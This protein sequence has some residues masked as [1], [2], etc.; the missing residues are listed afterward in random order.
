MQNRWIID[1]APLQ[2]YFSAVIFAPK[3]S[4]IRNIFERQIPWICRQ[5]KVPLAWSLELQKLE[6]HSDIVNAVAFSHDNQL[7]A[8]ASSEWTVMLWN[9]ATGELT[10][11]LEGHSNW[12]NSVMFSCDGQ[13]LASASDDEMV[14][15]WNPATGKLMRKLEGHWSAV[16]A[17][18][19][20]HD[21]QLLASASNDAKIALWDPA[22]GKLMRRLGYHNLRQIQCPI[23]ICLRWI[24]AG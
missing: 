8:S 1:T 5:P 23:G 16:N 14:M 3:T 20:S 7:L 13:L 11:K 19:F 10:Q 6:G 12:I 4:I 22:T 2:L 24:W 15:L 17:V 21:N 18:A 9:L